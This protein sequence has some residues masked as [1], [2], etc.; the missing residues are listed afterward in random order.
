M[1]VLLHI[2]CGPCAIYPVQALREAGHEVHGFFYNPNIHPYQEF[3]R[4]LTALE[5][6][7]QRHPLPMIWERSYDLENFLRLVVFREAERCRF[8]Y[9][10]R[11]AAT[12]RAARESSVDAFTSTLLY[13]KFQN[14]E[15]IR[16]IGEQVAE[17][18]NVPFYYEDFRR[19]WGQGVAAS[20]E[21]GLYR[22]P[23]CGCV[24]SERDRYYR[25]QSKVP[26]SLNQERKPKTKN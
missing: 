12:A 15:L 16:G 22:Q 26:Q 6:Y 8:C 5:D 24:Y 4:R 9:Q 17:D 14:H 19:G 3:A 23:Y 21:M 1:K 2:C 18:L 10:M 20:K 11:L 7:L 25:P 13:S